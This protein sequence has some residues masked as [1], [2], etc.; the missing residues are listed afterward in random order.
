MAALLGNYEETMG[1]NE[2][3]AKTQTISMVAGG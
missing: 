3:I 1:K 2:E